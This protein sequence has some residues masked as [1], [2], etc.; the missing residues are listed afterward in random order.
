MN[1][2]ENLITLKIEGA[3]SEE[4][5]VRADEFLAEVNDLLV[6]L[7]G[8]DRIVGQTAQPTLYY[9]IVA[10]SH[11]SPLSITLRPVLKP[12]VKAEPDHIA[13]RHHRFFRELS[14]IRNAEPVSPEVDEQLLGTLQDLSAS[15]RESFS[16]ASIS[17]S[18][19]SVDLDEVFEKNIRKMLGNE[20]TSY[21]AM[22]GKLE[23][24]N[25]HGTTR[26]FWIY[27]TIAQ[28]VRCDFLPGTQQQVLDSVGHYVHVEGL[29][30]FRPQSPFPLRI[31]VRDFNVI[32]EEPSSLIKLRGIAPDATGQ[33]S[34]VDFVRAIRD[35][36]DE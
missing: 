23:A 35:E 2:D 3:I 15:I 36:W 11:Q 8:I 1:G 26:R 17:N 31:A 28:R 4:G 29:K 25:I 24:I 5:H 13:V 20:Y 22:E 21:G 18:E 30:Y 14:A 34:S 33:L 7:N 9:R 32:D 6:A 27:P 12:R 19:A 10:V 16:N